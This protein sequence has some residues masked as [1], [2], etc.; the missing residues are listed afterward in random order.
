MISNKLPTQESF[1]EDVKDHAMDLKMDVGCHRHIVFGKPKNSNMWFEIV[2]WPRCL[3]ISG[4]MGTYV[5][6]RVEDM[7]AFF[8]HDEINPDYW[9][10][11]LEA[12]CNTDGFEEFSPTKCR[13]D[14]LDYISEIEDDDLKEEVQSEI[15]DLIDSGDATEEEIRKSL[16]DFEFNGKF[17]L[18]DFCYSDFKDYKYRFI[19]CLYAITWAIK[20]YDKFKAMLES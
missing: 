4:D 5:F 3:A 7:F 11:K 1:L 6:R 20:R 19:W 15:I 2:T 18:Y 10:E 14:V 13:A 9:S 8:R 12:V 17:P 16:S